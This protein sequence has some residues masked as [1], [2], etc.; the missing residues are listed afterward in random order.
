MKISPLDEFHKRNGAFFLQQEGWQLPSHFGNL[1][2]EYDSVRSQVA[3]LD[4]ADRAI[5]AVEGPDSVEWLQGMLSNDVK[6]LEPGDGI[7]AAVLNIKGKVVADVRVFR[8]TEALLLDVAEPQVSG[9]LEHLNQYLIADDV[10]ISDLSNDLTMLSLQ[11]PAAASTLSQLLDSGSLPIHNMNHTQIECAGNKIRAIHATHS[12]QPGFD[13]VIS[14]EMVLAIV[15]LP[16]A[17]A[18]PW[19]GMDTQEIL[20][21]EGGVPKYGIDMNADTLLL[22]TCMD[23]AI[24]FTKG[25]YLGQETVE[26]LHSRGHVNRKLVG[27]KVFGVLTPNPGAAI[28]A[29]KQNIGRVT[30]AI[31]SP[32]FQ[33]PVALGYVH[34]DHIN[35]G[36]V[37]SIEHGGMELS[38]TVQPLPF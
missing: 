23:D 15:R 27:L 3:W 12:G 2:K 32:R 29:T 35:P 38:A 31:A 36:T 30:S 37:V 25:C 8:T 28:C 26:R 16:N 24:S 9:L 1:R 14:R 11:G 34:K 13:L 5:L 17:Q 4:L 19:F 7:R 33:C 21:I 10:H 6:A 18:I 20:R 22:E